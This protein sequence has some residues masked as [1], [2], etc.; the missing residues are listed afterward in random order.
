MPNRCHQITVRLDATR[1]IS[2]LTIEQRASIPESLRRNI[3]NR[4]FGCDDCQ[5]ICPWNRYAV[6]APAPEFT[7]REYLNEAQLVDLFAG[8]KLNLKSERAARNSPHRLYWLA[9]QP[10]Q[11]WAMPQPVLRLRKHYGCVYTTPALSFVNTSS[12]AARAAKKQLFKTSYELSL[13]ESAKN[14]CGT[15]TLLWN[16][17]SCNAK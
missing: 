16:V 7:A 14:V 2:Y 8:L 11:R 4:I 17:T 5:L 10:A 6:S 3:G 13:A 9:A 12:G 1:C 15:L